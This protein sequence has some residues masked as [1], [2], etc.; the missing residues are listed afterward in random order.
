MGENCEYSQVS[1]NKTHGSF[2][3]LLNVIL[4]DYPFWYYVRIVMG[5][6]NAVK[7]QVMCSKAW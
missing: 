2:E 5:L 7:W 3:V 4:A 6:Q 1:R